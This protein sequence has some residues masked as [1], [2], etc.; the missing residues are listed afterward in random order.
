MCREN[1]GSTGTKD[2]DNWHQNWDFLHGELM[3]VSVGYGPVFW[4]VDYGHHVWYR[5]HGKVIIET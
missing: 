2:G 5:E 1:I 3:D 4:G